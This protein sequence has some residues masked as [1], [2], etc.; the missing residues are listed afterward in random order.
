VQGEAT[1][2]SRA[3]TQSVSPLERLI[4][5]FT[6]AFNLRHYDALEAWEA[7]AKREISA[8]AEARRRSIGQLFRHASRRLATNGGK[9]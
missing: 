2:R 8:M 3:T 4:D 1:A 5:D 7:K 9:S 6:L